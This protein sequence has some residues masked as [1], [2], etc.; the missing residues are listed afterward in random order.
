MAS[1]GQQR[2]CAR[3]DI[4][5]CELLFQRNC[6]SGNATFILYLYCITSRLEAIRQ[7]VVRLLLSVDHLRGNCSDEDLSSCE[8]KLE[9]A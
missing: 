4:L 9:C 8:A 2:R 3:P 6:C 1:C 7:V 5:P